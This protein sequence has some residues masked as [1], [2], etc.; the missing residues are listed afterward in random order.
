MQPL[1][2]A[3]SSLPTGYTGVR[4]SIDGGTTWSKK[5]PTA[6]KAGTYKVQVKYVGD[7]N[8]TS[9]VAAKA[10]DAKILSGAYAVVT[11]KLPHANMQRNTAMAIRELSRCYHVVAARQLFH[12]RSEVTLLAKVRREAAWKGEN[13]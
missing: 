10:I 6:K 3:P 12:N 11:L 9:F 1:V 8:H 4:Y 2:T 5:I 7:K 13:Q